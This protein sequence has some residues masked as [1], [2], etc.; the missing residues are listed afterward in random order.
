MSGQDYSGRSAASNSLPTRRLLAR[1]PLLHSRNGCKMIMGVSV[2]RA[3]VSGL[4]VAAVSAFALTACAKRDSAVTMAGA[5]A[6][7]NWRIERQVDRISGAP[8]SS[9]YLLTR[10]VSSSAIVF[11]PPAQLQVTCFKDRPL[12]RLGF[13][14]KV[15]SNRNSVLGYRFDQNPGREPHA[16]FL[17][18]YRTVV[19]ED[20][21][22]VAQFVRE[23]AVSKVLYVRIRSL[24][25]PRSSAEFKL[26]G[27]PAAIEAGLAGCSPMRA[28][29]APHNIGRGR[30]G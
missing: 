22:D 28:Q 30:R 24:N 1:N 20:Q 21:N 3:G 2:V 15:G 29:S 27:A 13:D 18:D 5:T 7:G 11:P 12:V 23:L 4:A 10:S 6:A 26:D 16:R 25:A 14:F 9:A 19:I 17:Q 8:I